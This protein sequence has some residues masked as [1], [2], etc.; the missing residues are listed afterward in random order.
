MR[1]TK[2]NKRKEKT[3]HSKTKHPKTKCGNAI[4]DEVLKFRG[5]INKMRK[6]RKNKV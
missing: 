6:T 5:I 2:A 1:N 3:K 4:T